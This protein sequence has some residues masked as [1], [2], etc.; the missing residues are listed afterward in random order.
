[1]TWP[2]SQMVASR[3]G[4]MG[5]LSVTL[6]RKR[7]WEVGSQ[8]NTQERERKPYT[9]TCSILTHTRSIYPPLRT[10][11]HSF[12]ISLSLSLSLPLPS[13]FPPSLLRSLPSYL[14]LVHTHTCACTHTHTPSCLLL[15][16]N[17]PLSFVCTH[18]HQ[19]TYTPLPALFTHAG[20]IALVRDDD[21]IKITMNKDP[22]QSGEINVLG[23][24]EAD[25]EARK[26]RVCV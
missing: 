5:S 6:P 26:V 20:P 9:C 22:A 21:I 8:G 2:S 18:P 24:T 25:W 10:P 1:M 3:V 13:S 16:P 17:S 11:S 19:H 7:K 15:P 14:F 23:V 4:P 12:P